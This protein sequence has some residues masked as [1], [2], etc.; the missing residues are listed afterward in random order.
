MKLIVGLG[1]PGKEYENTRHN[2]GFMVLDSYLGDVKWSSKFNGLYYQ[3][4]INGEK[5]IFLKPQSYMNL[6]G[7]VVRKYMDYFKITFEDILVIHDDL[8]LEVGRVR[9]KINSS[10]GGHNGIKDIIACLKTDA[11]ARI[12]VGVSNNKNV[13]TKDYVL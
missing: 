3:S 9:I 10:A 5:Y 13:D 11:F 4:V 1:N 12:K 7:G 2:I 6:S 8:D